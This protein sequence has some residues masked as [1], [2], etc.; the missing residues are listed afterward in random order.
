MVEWHYQGMEAVYTWD[1][2][3][4]RSDASKDDLKFTSVSTSDIPQDIWDQVENPYG[5]NWHKYSFSSA[6]EDEHTIL[7]RKV[8]MAG[9]KLI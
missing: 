4:G 6:K 5:G 3:M 1:Y 2:A 9:N 7:K 8:R